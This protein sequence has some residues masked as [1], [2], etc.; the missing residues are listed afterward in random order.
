LG[1]AS[2][3][4]ETIKV[5]YQTTVESRLHGGIGRESYQ[6]ESLTFE[7]SASASGSSGSSEVDVEGDASCK[8]EAEAE[9]RHDGAGNHKPDARDVDVSS[10]KGCRQR[11]W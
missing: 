9:P 7:Q 1:I 3:N 5:G 2:I 11:E 8:S 6:G 4:I 10:S